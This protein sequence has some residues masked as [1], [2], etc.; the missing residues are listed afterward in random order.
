MHIKSQYYLDTE[1]K[2][3]RRKGKTSF[4]NMAVNILEKI[5]AK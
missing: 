4:M 2:E 3:I 1:I 5:L